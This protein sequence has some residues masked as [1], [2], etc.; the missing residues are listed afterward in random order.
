[1]VHKADGSAEAQTADGGSRAGQLPLLV[2]GQ[3]D[4]IRL[5]RELETI[6]ETLLSH[7]LRQQAT[8]AHMLKTSR[9]MDQLININKLNLLQRSDRERLARFLKTVKER[10]PVLHISF[11][12]DPTPSFMERLMAWLRQ[13]IHP[14][15]LVSTG[16]QPTLAAGCVVRSTN[17]YFD[18]SLHQNFTDKRDILIGQLQASAGAEKSGNG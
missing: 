16:V 4:I 15:V 13:E 10:A 5:Q 1:M 3:M 17:K 6:D 14:Q 2:V 7:T 11:S 8:E 9:L 12:A 18:F